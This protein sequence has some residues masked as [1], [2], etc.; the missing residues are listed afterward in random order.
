MDTLLQKLFAQ[1]ELV[2]ESA[3]LALIGSLSARHVNLGTARITAAAQ[4]PSCS[5][6]VD[7]ALHWA[8]KNV[9][10]GSNR[11][12]V[13]MRAV[14]REAALEIR[15][16]PLFEFLGELLD[17]RGLAAWAVAQFELPS[18]SE[19]LRRVAHR[20][21]DQI[22]GSAAVVTQVQGVPRELPVPRGERVGAAAG[23]D[24]GEE[25]VALP[26]RSGVGA[27]SGAASGPET[28]D[29]L[30]EMRASQ[31]RGALDELEPVRKEH[32]DKWA[33][34]NAAEPLDHGTVDRHALHLPRCDPDGDVMRAIGR[35]D[36]ELHP[37]G[38]GIEPHKLTVIRC[39]TRA[40]RAAQIER[41]EQ[42]RLAG[43]VGTVDDG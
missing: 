31:R 11:K 24:T 14:A 15:G 19:T 5:P 43:T 13:A 40:R 3:D 36:S 18:E 39:A 10:K 4:D 6:I 23:A 17:G 34:W 29:E 32:R 2:P 26:E 9:G 7:A 33:T 38:A 8:Q 20:S 21:T 12:L 28:R 16:E 37:G 25:G 1:T 22:D 30:V 42:I 41:L 35:I 27:A